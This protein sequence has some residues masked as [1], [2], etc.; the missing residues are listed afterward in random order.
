MDTNFYISIAVSAGAGSALVQLLIQLGLSHWLQKRYHSYTLAK[1][2]RRNCADRII[3]LV[4]PKNYNCWSNR[5]DDIYNKAYKL[6]DKMLSLG[7]K[8]HSKI[9]DDYTSAQIYAQQILARVLSGNS[10]K[11]D[12]NEFLDSQHTV[13]MLRNQLIETAKILKAK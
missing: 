6:S 12:E 10:Q 3:E 9:L 4:N 2:D 1:A 11:E 13:E 8:K 7:E 5:N